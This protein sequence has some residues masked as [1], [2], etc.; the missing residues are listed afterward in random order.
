MGLYVKADA[1]CGYGIKVF[2]SGTQ[3]IVTS[4]SKSPKAPD[5]TILNP[6]KVEVEKTGKG[7]YLCLLEGFFPDVIKVVWYKKGNN[8]EL[9]SEQGEIKLDDKSKLYSVSSWITVR[10]SDLGNNF[11]CKFKHEGVS[12]AE[13]WGE[14]ATEEYTS[15]KENPTEN[16]NEIQI[17]EN[18]AY[19]ADNST[20]D[21]V[22]LSPVN[23]TI[24]RA[25]YFTYILLLLK[26]A[27]YCS[28]LLF[29]MCRTTVRFSP[30]SKNIK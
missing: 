6:S 18:C 23:P 16:K 30:K 7:T 3:L 25:A 21:V 24:Y 8:N 20:E 19:R 4:E 13:H 12:A 2:G 15:G 29:F 28:I 22:Y 17:G 26:S 9:E 5:V 11:I 27:T 1:Q 14:T 10:K